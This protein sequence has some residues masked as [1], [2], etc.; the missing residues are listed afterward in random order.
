MR[1]PFRKRGPSMILVLIYLVF[2]IY[3]INYP[4]NFLAIPEAVAGIDPWIIFIGGILI[5]LGMINYFRASR[6]FGY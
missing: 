5:L 1:D 4:F 6:R 2:A 3:F